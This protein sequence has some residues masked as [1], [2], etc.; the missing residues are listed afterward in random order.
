MSQIHRRDLL[1]RRD[2]LEKTLAGEAADRTPVA[3]WRPFPGDDRR[4]ADLARSTVE[5]QRQ[6]DWDFVVLCPA[7]NYAVLDYGVQ[8]AWQGAADGAYTVLR[9]PVNRSLDWTELRPVDPSRGEHGRVLEA[10]RLVIEALRG[11]GVPVLVTVYSPLAQARRLTG[12]PLFIRHFR[13]HID[14]VRTGLTALTES[15][16]RFIEALRPV[17]I[18]GIYYVVEHADL[19][20]FS[21][22]EYDLYGL[23]FDRKLLE[24]LPA[25]WWLNILHWQG[26]SPMLRF[27]GSYRVQAINGAFTPE[28]AAALRPLFAGAICGGLDLELQ[29]RQG[30]PTSIR[31]DARSVMQTMSARR[32]ILGASGPALITTPRSNLQAL[33]EAVGQV[34]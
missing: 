7:S 26:G 23:P 8:D 13:R 15:T 17:G 33:R 12:N 3:I 19:D 16:L 2:L 22:S 9:S 34:G 20:V 31:D 11:S 4:A 27:G 24:A 6:Y 14:R 30:T 1:D 25:G 5:F 18:D 29:L 28:D 21:E 10:T 32:L